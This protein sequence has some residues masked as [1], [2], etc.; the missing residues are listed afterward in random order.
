MGLGVLTI[1]AALY[2]LSRDA[3]TVTFDPKK[4][5]VEELRRI[6]HEMFVE[7]ATLYCQKLNL[8]RQAKASGEFKSDTLENFIRKQEQE[9]DEAEQDIYKEN[10]ITEE[11]FADWLSKH[12][13]DSVI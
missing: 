6:C 9:M 2:L 7:G 4:H 3:E 5:T 8:M 13:G 10:K 1:G 11:F 12:K